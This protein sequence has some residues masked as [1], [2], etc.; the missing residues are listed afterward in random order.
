MLLHCLKKDS[1]EGEIAVLLEEIVAFF[2]WA[3]PQVVAFE[4]VHRILLVLNMGLAVVIV[5]ASFQVTIGEQ[6][7]KSFVIANHA[8]LIVL[9]R[10]MENAVPCTH[11]LFFKQDACDI[12]CHD[13][14]L[15]YRLLA[16]LDLGV[17]PEHLGSPLYQEHVEG[18]LRCSKGVPRRR[19]IKVSKQVVLVKEES[20][21]IK[22]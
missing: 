22:E 13:L 3:A 9:L 10:K 18:E 8:D 4:A 17:D 1:S 7:Q 11:F 20:V 14:A 2:V 19:A 21:V 15:E 5:C 12:F 16:P 6:F